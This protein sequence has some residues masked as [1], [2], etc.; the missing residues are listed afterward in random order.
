MSQRPAGIVNYDL[1]RA[2]AGQLNPAAV[3]QAFQW[4]AGSGPF[5]HP[6]SVHYDLTLRCTARCIHC[7]QW[8][9]P[10]TDELSLGQIHQLL[11]VLG[12][13]GVKTM[14]LGG[15]NPLLHPEFP[16]VLFAARANGIASG[17][18]SEGLGT[19]PSQWANS[20]V[21]CAS[22][23]RLSLDG[24][25]ATI[26]DRIRNAP[27]LFERVV[28]DVS[29]LRA[30]SPKFPIALNCVIQKENLHHLEDMIRLAEAIGA[31]AVLFK[32]A[33]GRDPAGRYLLDEAQ[34]KHLLDWVTRAENSTYRVATNLSHF[35][36]LL[37]DVY[38]PRDI[39]VGRPVRSYYVKNSA[40]CFVP[41]FFLICDSRGNAYPCDYLQADTR[42][43][44]QPFTVLRNEFCLGNLL[45]DAEGV[46]ARLETLMETR[47]HRLPGNGFDECGSCTRFCQINA[48][49]SKLLEDLGTTDPTAVA[50][51]EFMP[52]FDR[53]K[54]E[55]FL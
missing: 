16:G 12:G 53:S 52:P 5:P 55:P 13:W 7:Y 25:N 15:G 43:W 44:T 24:P 29:A 31:T 17:I 32:L 38:L 22:W 27:G 2:E 41:F 51:R 23:I 54:G 47:I 14:T 48:F 50:L 9:W 36:T 20:I 8:S 10:S 35:A 30:V 46:R 26:H 40:R 39:A 45:N 3:S 37:R 4:I 34:C 11:A 6:Q 33:H 42:P 49:F 1:F 21:E 19:L 28:A 18:I